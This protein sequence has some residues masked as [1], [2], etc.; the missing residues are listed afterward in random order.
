M[1]IV[2]DDD[3]DWGET[4]A[5]KLRMLGFNVKVCLTF[6]DQP[7]ATVFLVDAQ[8]KGIVVGP[9]FVMSLRANHPDAIIIGMSSKLDFIQASMTQ[10]VREQFLAAGANYAVS[11]EN[12]TTTLKSLFSQ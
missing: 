11:T 7:E 1:A 12:V 3:I 10:T 9:G 2:I 4:V 5:E 8:D 6:C